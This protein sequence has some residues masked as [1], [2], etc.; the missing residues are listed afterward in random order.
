MRFAQR[1]PFKFF[2]LVF[3]LT[4]PFWILGALAAYQLL[5]ALP[6]SALSF[7]CPVLAA[8]ILLYRSDGWIG[9]TALLRRSFDLGRIRSKRWLAA[10]ILLEPA[11]MVLS[12]AVIRM[13][14]VPVPAP[15]IALL[16]ALALFVVFFIAALGEELGWSGYATDPLQARFGGLGAS[17]VIG[18]VWVGW[19]FIG[20]AQAN[21]SVAFI[22]WWSLSTLAYRV[23]IV[24]LYNHTGRS[25]SAAAVFHA[26]INLTWQL[27]PVNGSFYDPRITGLIAAVMAVMAV[28]VW[29]PRTLARNNAVSAG[30]SD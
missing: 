1:S 18:L 15:Q 20:L 22:A 10:A 2:G 30:R 27:F 14:G 28:V 7:F 4:L 8:A 24:R 23:I 21:R 5:P 26:M 13:M 25:V 11:I 12:F 6:L 17:L 29:R 16:P 9:V 3:A 19:H